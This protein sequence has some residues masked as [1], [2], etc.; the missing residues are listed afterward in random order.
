[1]EGEKEMKLRYVKLGDVLSVLDVKNVYIHLDILND[2]AEVIATD[3]LA[4][5][6]AKVE[7]IAD[8]AIVDS[9]EIDGDEIL[10]FAWLF[11]FDLPE[12]VEVTA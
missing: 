9:L 4:I 11:S 2:D 12:L 10:V 7:L 1:M 5:G 6:N 3:G 8:K